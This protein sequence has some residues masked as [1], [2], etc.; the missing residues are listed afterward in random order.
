MNGTGNESGIIIQKEGDWNII[1]MVNKPSARKF[2][3]MT[4]I[5][6]DYKLVLF[7]GY[8]GKRDLNDT[9]IHDFGNN[10]WQNCL[11]SDNPSVRDQAQ[12]TSIYGEDKT[13]LFGGQL[14]FCNTYEPVHELTSVVHR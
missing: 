8:D 11:T 4:A 12:I 2:G 13:I 14:Y 9:W 6:N 1:N 5:D 7:G 3:A 10:T